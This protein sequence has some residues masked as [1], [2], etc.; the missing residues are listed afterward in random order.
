MIEWGSHKST[1]WVET[2]TKMIMLRSC[3]PCLS[4]W[5]SLRHVL[6]VD[7]FRGEARCS[8]F[9]VFPCTVGLGESSATMG[10]SG[11]SQV[12]ERSSSRSK[13]RTRTRAEDDA[14]KSWTD[15]VQSASDRGRRPPPAVHHDT[16]L[17]TTE[18]ASPSLRRALQQRRTIRAYCSHF[19]LIDSNPSILACNMSQF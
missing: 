12:T 1:W 17:S 2:E 7:E 3:Q 10:E 8:H 16:H 5:M 15:S 11:T 18:L 4:F 13:D 14:R 9:D 6:C 19:I